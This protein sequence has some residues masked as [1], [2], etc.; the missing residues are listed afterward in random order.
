[1]DANNKLKE[2]NTEPVI[3]LI[4]PRGS[5]QEKVVSVTRKKAMTL[6]GIFAVVVVC[7]AGAA[8]VVLCYIRLAREW[9]WLI[10]ALLLPACCLLSIG[11]VLI[12][13]NIK[14]IRFN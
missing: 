14:E 13:D 12:R 8:G 10:A 7:L 3:Q 11:I 4:F 1:M 9:S 6:A 5:G 2:V